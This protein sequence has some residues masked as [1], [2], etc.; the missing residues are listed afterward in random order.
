MPRLPEVPGLPALPELPAA[1]D[2]SSAGGIADAARTAAGALGADLPPQV[3]DLLGA[4]AGAPGG[5]APA[6][7][8]A[9]P[10]GASA[11][12]VDEIYEGVIERLRRDLIVERERMGDLLGNLGH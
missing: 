6:A 8:G 12:N 10:G 9:A 1:P 7:A 2:L 5:A 4:A 11:P 3:T